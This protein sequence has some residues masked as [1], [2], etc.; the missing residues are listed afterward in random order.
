[1]SD[2]EYFEAVQQFYEDRLKSQLKEKFRKCKGCQGDKQFIEKPGQLIYSC[3]KSSKR[4]D[5]KGDKCGHQMTINLARYLHY[6]EM[7]EDVNKIMDGSMDLSLFDEIFSKEDIHKQHEII[8]DNAKL[9]KKCKKPFSEQNQLKARVNV[10]KKTHKN[11]IQLKV[12][13]NLLLHKLKKEED[14]DKKQTLM[15]EYLQ[16]N[17]RIKEEYDELLTSNKPLNN[18]LVIEE[19]SV[20]K[21]T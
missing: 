10:I 11:R 1:M 4:K 18:F 16:I 8:K 2:K 21:S 6:S 9:F 17:Q 14:L 3:G 13:Q 5:S 19:G 7:K 20:I 12:E 15:K